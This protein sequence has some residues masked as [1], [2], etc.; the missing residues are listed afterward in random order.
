[1]QRRSLVHSMHLPVS[2]LR[3]FPV[4]LS[5]SSPLYSPF[6][7]HSVETPDESLIFTATQSISCDSRR[8]VIVIFIQQIVNIMA[9]KKAYSKED[10]RKLMKQKLEASSTKGGTSEETTRI[11]SPLAAYDSQ[12]NLTCRVCTSR[13]RESQWTTHLLS[14][15]HKNR[16]EALRSAA[17]KGKTSSNQNVNNLLIP[18]HLLVLVRHQVPEGTVKNLSMSSH[19]LRKLRTL[20]K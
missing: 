1:M 19:L 16:I 17:I 11:D 18:I 5:F 9:Q 10:L 8:R 12:G 13:I 3:F 4:L 20:M 2:G 6:T 15:D 7:L 14:K